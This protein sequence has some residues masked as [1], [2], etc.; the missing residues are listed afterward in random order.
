MREASVPARL[1]HL[2][3]FV[4]A[5]KDGKDQALEPSRPHRIPYDLRNTCR[6]I[7]HRER[8]TPEEGN[9]EVLLRIEVSRP[10]GSKRGESQVEQR[11]FL[12]P[13]GDARVIP[14]P[15]NLGQYDRILV[16]VS[17]VADESRYALSATDRT[18]LPSAQWT[19]LIS[20]GLFRLY[21]TATIPAG[22][23]RATEPAGQLTVNFGLVSRLAL[24]NNEGQER[25]L[26]IELG[27]MGMGLVPQS[28]DIQFPPTLAIV[29]G[30]GLRVPIGPGAAVGAQAWVAREFR[31]E[32]KRRD[33]MG[34][35]IVVPS[36]KWSFIFGPSISV[37]NV[38]FNL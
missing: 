18:G 4:C 10:D 25:L 34:A 12:R 14:I 16:Q 11:M 5:D 35:D 28:G 13:K 17:H 3:E 15:G 29:A 21:T 20:G 30:L 26:G 27:L 37:G 22:L 1:E 24:L 36:S 32:I 7:V 33:P 19:A 8:L 2:L 31:D 6:V 38:G 23:Y 9:Q